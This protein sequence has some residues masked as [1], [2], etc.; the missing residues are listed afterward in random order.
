MVEQIFLLSQMKGSVMYVRVAS[1]VAERL[2]TKE[3]RKYHE[4]LKTA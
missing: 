3:I 4:N 1:Q 2:K